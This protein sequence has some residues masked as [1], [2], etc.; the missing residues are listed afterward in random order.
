MNQPD[1]KNP[2]GFCIVIPTIN[3]LDLLF[4][5]LLMYATQLPEV[6]I[7]IYDNGK[8]YIQ[9]KIHGL[10]NIRRWANAY[11]GLDNI[12]VYGGHGDNIGVAASWNFLCQ[13]AFERGYNYVVVL[14]D[15]IYLHLE[16]YD[17]WC[18]INRMFIDQTDFLSCVEK[19][20]RAAFVLSSKC[21]DVVGQF[22]DNFYPA[23]YEDSEYLYRLKLAK[24]RGRIDYGIAPLL[25]PHVFRRSSTILAQKE[26][27]IVSS[28]SKE[29]NKKYYILKW[30][31]DVGEEKFIDC[32]GG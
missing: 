22:D 20:E 23:Y 15:D 9:E 16:M 6:E 21:Y 26:E 14:N 28:E 4:P 27:S 11:K 31:G 1:K 12:T 8:Q 25:N 18:I 7:L 32:F 19:F 29:R 13:K 2:L 3:R 5:S 24:G 30:G 17:Y 10:R